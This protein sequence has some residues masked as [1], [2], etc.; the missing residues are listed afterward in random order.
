MP[1]IIELKPVWFLC[2]MIGY[3]DPTMNKSLLIALLLDLS[4][5]LSAQTLT[6]RVLD[7][8]TRE[9]IPLAS[10]YFDGTFAGTSTDDQGRFSLNVTD[11]RS[12]PLSFSAVGYVPFVWEDFDPGKSNVVLLRR[13]MY[14]IEEVTVFGEDME[15]MIARKRKAYM[16][17]FKTQFI[18]LTNN[19]RRC[20][21]MNEEDITFNY[22]SDRDT[23]RA[24]ALKP[25][26]IQNDALGYH[27]MYFLDSFEY[28]KETKGVSYQGSI[29]FTRDLLKE[30]SN[31]AV[32]RRRRSYA[33]KG[34]SKEFIRKIWGNSLK[35]SGYSVR[36][37]YSDKNL[38]YKDLVY[39]DPEGNKYLKYPGDLD[40]RYYNYS[41]S[42]RLLIPEVFIDRD[43]FFDPTAIDWGGRM[44]GKRIADFLPYEYKPGR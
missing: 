37:Y 7:A 41:S 11:Y 26:E 35:S 43:G 14:Q 36:D 42:I 9:P 4:L 31:K 13:E 12:R 17:L 21:L 18:G 39:K 1:C 2:D 6:G 20:Y 8:D 44:A 23:I 5:S 38:K 10:V 3:S 24:I 22:D 19:A 30:G 34:S 15:K 27:F 40:I 28:A 33:Y 32:Y 16:R 29:V 25:L